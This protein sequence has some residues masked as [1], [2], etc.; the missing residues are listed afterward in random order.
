M[1]G[2]AAARARRPRPSAARRC[3]DSAPIAAI[4]WL[5]EASRARE[6]GFR[7]VPSQAGHGS[8]TTSSTS[9]SRREGLLAALV[10]VVA[11]RVVVGLAL[12]ARQRQ[13]GADAVGAPAVLAVVREQARVQLGVAGAADRAG[14]LG[15]EHLDLADARASARR[16]AIAPLQAVERRAARASRPCRAPA[17]CASSSRSS[18]SFAGVDDEVAHRQLDRVLLEAVDARQRVD[19][20]NSPSTRRCV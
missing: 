19:G 5:V 1:L 15:R 10:V 18:A 7:R 8:S 12:L 6:A 17:P 16:P 13:A 3:T 2:V 20:R 11:H 14:A 4:G 9:G